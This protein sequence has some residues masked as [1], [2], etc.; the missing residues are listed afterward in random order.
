MPPHT[1]FTYLL[2]QLLIQAAVSAQWREPLLK[3]AK[4]S[5]QEAQAMSEASEAGARKAF[6]MRSRPHIQTACT[7]CAEKDYSEPCPAGWRDL[8]GGG[9]VAPPGYHGMCS[10]Q[11]SFVGGSA[12][13]KEEVEAICGVC[14]P[15]K[16]AA[17]CARD[18]SAACPHGFSKAS[19]ELDEFADAPGNT[20]NSDLAYEGPCAGQV[21]FGSLAEKQAFADRCQVSWP[22]QTHCEGHVP[23]RCPVAWRHI[24]DGMCVAPPDFKV[25]GCRLVRS[26]EGWTPGMKTVFAEQCQ[27]TWPCE[28][29]PNTSAPLVDGP[30]RDDSC[31]LDL[32]P[33]AC[34]RSWARG[35][36]GLCEPSHGTLGPCA[37][38]TRFDAMSVEQKIM[39][40]SDC[41]ARWKCVGEPAEGAERAPLG[42]SQAN[43]MERG[44]LDDSGKVVPVS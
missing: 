43:T 20:C 42:V 32:A 18:W 24:G 41:F 35:L 44:P 29:A 10:V 23:S 37:R 30:A 33:T 15:C 14:W 21:S 8:E 13:E 2:A 26:F 5:A 31:Q 22:C 1:G 36:D 9:C 38:P 28:P 11:Q 7:P 40:A 39:W 3:A 6:G 25:A 12:L 16:G 17:G 27:V 34:P 4:V 19:I